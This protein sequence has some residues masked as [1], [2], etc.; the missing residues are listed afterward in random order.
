MVLTERF[1]K[2]TRAAVHGLAS[3]ITL[4]ALLTLHTTGYTMSAQSPTKY[5]DGQYL[6]A[7]A[8]IDH[9]DMP[10]LVAAI[11]GLKVDNPGREHM[12]LLWYAIQKKNY[13]AI[14]TLVKKGSQP[15]QQG[16]EGLGTPLY[17]ALMNQDTRLLEAMLDGGL[18]PDFQ[19]EDGRTLLQL[20]MVSDKAADL[21]RLLVGRKA[22]VNLA[23]SIGRTPLDAAIDANHPEL[24]MYLIEHGANVNTHMSNGVSPA[25]SVQ[26]EIDHLQPNAKQAP[27]TDISLDNK[28]KPVESTGTPVAQGSTSAGQELLKEFEQLRAL[29]IQKGA[30]FPPDPPAKV[31]EQMRK[32]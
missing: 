24:G 11:P 10:S 7:A 8:A 26:W 19:D 32:K 9:G 13:E 29:M 20:A 12:T 30:K 31:R 1:L 25:Y 17:V 28:G 14:Q 22:N 2:N 5:F 16:V 23:D 6:T 3:V 4:I 21:V 15:E 18:S 27:V